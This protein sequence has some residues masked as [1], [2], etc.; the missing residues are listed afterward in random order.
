M[1]IVYRDGRFTHKLSFHYIFFTKAP[2]ENLGQSIMSGKISPNTGWTE[3]WL[4]QQLGY[5]CIDSREMNAPVIMIVNFPEHH[6]QYR[7][8]SI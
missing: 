1:D 6:L 7:S 8:E 3:C 2:N 5:Y 4:S